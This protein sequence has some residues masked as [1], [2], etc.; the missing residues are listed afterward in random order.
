MDL[1]NIDME[2]RGRRYI[3][4]YGGL[5]VTSILYAGLIYYRVP[6]LPRLASIYCPVAFAVGYFTSAE[7]GL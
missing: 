5:A 2:E 7:Q 6:L 3:A 1:V 4:A